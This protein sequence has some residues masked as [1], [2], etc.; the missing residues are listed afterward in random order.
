MSDITLKI[1]IFKS[2]SKRSSF[3]TVMIGDGKLFTITL[4]VGRTYK[5]IKT[6]VFIIAS[7]DGV[8]NA[9][10]CSY[11]NWYCVYNIRCT[12]YKKW[13]F[14]WLLLD[15]YKLWR[16]LIDSGCTNSCNG[17][18]YSTCYLSNTT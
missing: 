12:R 8:V 9:L 7:S 10:M 16:R 6:Y 5:T 11:P 14:L 4:C 13:L 1:Q 15:G 18:C 2:S 17:F 3:Y